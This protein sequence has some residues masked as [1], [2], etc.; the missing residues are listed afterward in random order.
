[1]RKAGIAECVALT[2]AASISAL[3]AES[4]GPVGYTGVATR[5]QIFVVPMSTAT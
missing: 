5:Q 1:M 3:S 2:E 4:V